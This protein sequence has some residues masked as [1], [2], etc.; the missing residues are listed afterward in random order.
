MDPALPMVEVERVEEE[1]RQSLRL[2]VHHPDR[3]ADQ[4]VEPRQFRPARDQGSQRRM[5]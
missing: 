4:I 3:A 5:A 2:R 1:E